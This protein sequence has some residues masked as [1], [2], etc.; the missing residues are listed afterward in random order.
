MFHFFSFFLGERFGLI[1]RGINGAA[2]CND[3]GLKRNSVTLP[4]ILAGINSTT[5]Q[6]NA[7]PLQ[8]QL[9]DMRLRNED[10][11]H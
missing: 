2:N 11:I 5:L 3:C 8:L 9:F 10:S 4:N 7:V 1:A 6:A